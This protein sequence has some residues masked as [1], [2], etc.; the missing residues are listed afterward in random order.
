M[1]VSTPFYT[2]G[3]LAAGAAPNRHRGAGAW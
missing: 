3:S 2:T 1:R